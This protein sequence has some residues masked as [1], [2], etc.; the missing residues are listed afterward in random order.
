MDYDSRPG[1]RTVYGSLQAMFNAK[2]DLAI[3]EGNNLFVYEAKFTSRFS[4]KQMKRTTEI[5]EVW[6]ELLYSDFGFN[7][8]PEVQVLKLGME[9]DGVDVSWE[10]IYDLAKKHLGESD[11]SMRSISKVMNI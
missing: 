11:Y 2:P 8:K 7:S 9:R 6:R 5:S 3:C 1:D 4:E 10:R